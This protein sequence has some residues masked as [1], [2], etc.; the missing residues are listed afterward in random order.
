M[1]GQFLAPTVGDDARDAPR[2]CLDVRERRHEDE[3]PPAFGHG[4][5]DDVRRVIVEGR[6]ARPVLHERRRNVAVGQGEG[7]GAE[8]VQVGADRLV[9]AGQAVGADRPQKGFEIVDQPGVFPCRGQVS[10]RERL[11]PLQGFRENGAVAVDMQF[12]VR[13]VQRAGRLS[14]FLSPSLEED[15]QPPN[16]Q[17]P[18]EGPCSNS[19]SIGSSPVSESR[20]WQSHRRGDRP[21]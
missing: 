6:V 15:P 17:A 7:H 5:A 8:V 10:V 16:C 14:D 4:L 9:N 21:C 11:R 3:Y 18:R 12:A 1:G 13:E 2:H 19:E 20:L